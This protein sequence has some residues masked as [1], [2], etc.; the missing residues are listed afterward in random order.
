MNRQHFL[1]SRVICLVC[2]GAGM[3]RANA[4]D[5]Q[6]EYNRLYPSGERDGDNFGLATDISGDYA[7]IGA[8][9]RDQRGTDSGAAFLFNVSRGL[10]VAVLLASDGASQDRFGNAV[11][12]SGPTILVGAERRADQGPSSGAAYVFDLASGIQTLKILPPDGGAG[13][14]FGY[15]VELEDRTALIG[16]Y[17]DT[18]NG[19]SAGSAYVYDAVTGHLHLKLL[20]PDPTEDHF[21]G[22]DL[23]LG[24]TTALVGASGDDDTGESAGA[25]YQ[26]EMPRGF[27][28]RK[29]NAADGEESDRF[30][31]TV[32]LSGDIA[33]IGAPGD[34]PRGDS[35]GSA[36][37]FD[38]RSGEQIAKLVPADGHGG[39]KFGDSVAIDGDIAL[40]GASDDDGGAFQGGAGYFF[41]ANNGRQIVKIVASNPINQSH[42]GSAVA[43]G[44]TTAVVGV[45]QTYANE[46]RTG[47]AYVF[48]VPRPCLQLA[49]DRVVAGQETTF[50]ISNGTPGVNAI[51]VYGFDQGETLANRLGGYC[52]TF[53]IAGVS[54][55]NVISGFGQQF[56]A[57]GKITF[58]GRIP[59]WA[60]GVTL[61]FQAAM[62][63]TCP[64]QCVSDLVI[65]TVQ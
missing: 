16:A 18:M 29:L 1:V 27:F 20:P 31:R 50:T 59:R 15:A 63:G 13:H 25:V 7:I 38:L 52:A 44:P 41:D 51:T 60:Y 35:S 11:A 36:Y 9:N 54:L 6:H 56:D 47:A 48:E 39:A 5:L 65:E 61:H 12:I 22:V 49:V 43:M 23:D 57:D 26:F 42:L 34:N 24:E 19:E 33:V 8:P 55:G 2:A 10:Q 46:Y 4:Q 17:G 3:T 14:H 21:F 30:G 32:A 37:L 40:V 28:I 64:Y 45:P 58:K 62:Q 53:N